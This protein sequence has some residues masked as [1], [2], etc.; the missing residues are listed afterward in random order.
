LILQEFAVMDEHCAATKKRKLGVIG[1]GSAGILSLVHFC[2]WLDN[3]WEVYSIYNPAKP[4]LGIGESTNGE[5]IALLERGIRFGLGNKTDLDALD[6]TLK[7]GSRFKNWREHSWINPLLNGNTAIHFNNFNFKNFAFERL[8]KLWPQQFRILEGDVQAMANHTDRVVV[9]VNGENH[10]FDFIVDCMGT[11]ASFENYVISDCSPVNRCQIHSV[12]DFEFEPFTD[13]IAH[14][15]GWMFG[16][17][18]QSRKTFGYLYNDTITPKEEAIADMKQ[19]LGV[20]EI[21]DKEYKFQ[22]YYTRNMATGRICKNGNKALFFE[23]LVAN[24]IFVYLNT[25]RLIYDYIKGT[26]DVDKTNAAFVKMVQEMED[27]IS[28]YYQ[29][30]STFTSKF[31]DYAT[32]HTKARMKDRQEFKDIMST[33]RSLK[34]RGQLYS[35]PSYG[36]KALTW[37]IIDEQMGYG[38]IDGI[39]IDLDQYLWSDDF[40]QRVPA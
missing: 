6:A 5:F 25:N 26:T 2:T 3:D 29:G 11:P 15:N 23:P 39:P 33:Y 16:V 12:K 10:E 21:E 8:H 30:G 34:E 1:A 18:L 9:T 36:V 14:K 7:F 31:W 40:G 37:E 38:Y 32:R 28:Y 13:H 24:S 22:C 20:T 27:I 19:L 17:P 35:A 4:I